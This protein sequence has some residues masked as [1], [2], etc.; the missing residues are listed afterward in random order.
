MARRSPHDS[1]VSDD[2]PERQA[3]RSAAEL[4]A[5]VLDSAIAIPG[6][7]I[8]IGLDPLFGLVPG[9]GDAFASAVGSVILL[10]AAR[11]RVPKIVLVRMG[12]NLLIN[13]VVGMIPFAGDAFSVWFQ[14]NRLNA[15]LLAE[16]A[17]PATAR[18][19]AGDWLAVGAVLLVCLSTV[20]GAMVLVLWL[21]GRIGQLIQ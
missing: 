18:S 20:I 16:C 8:R 2:D 14:S 12:M 17:G 10:I 6:T 7:Q 19:T 21:A 1:E 11:L 5:R 9:I 13:G 4:L 3:L 15:R